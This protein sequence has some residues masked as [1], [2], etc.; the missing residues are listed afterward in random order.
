MSLVRRKEY[1]EKPKNMSEEKPPE[2][3]VL[4]II[5]EMKNVEFGN[6]RGDL[7]AD[8]RGEGDGVKKSAD[9]SGDDSAADIEEGKESRKEKDDGNSADQAGDKGSEE[10]FE[11][12]LYA[13][14]VDDDELDGE[15]DVQEGAED[16]LDLKIDSSLKDTDSVLYE[17][18]N[19]VVFSAGDNYRHVVPKIKEITEEEVSPLMS[20]HSRKYL[21]MCIAD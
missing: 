20:W 15:D 1:M 9:E 21:A 13:D 11:D 19:E 7:V 5:T 14:A 4:G 18:D 17:W 6:G 16:E 2:D 8:T 3:A 10:D 12:K